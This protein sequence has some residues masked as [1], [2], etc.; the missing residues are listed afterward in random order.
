MPC[1]EFEADPNHSCIFQPYHM[2]FER[3]LTDAEWKRFGERVDEA[4]N[5]ETWAPCKV[6]MIAKE[7]LG[8]SVVR[9][10]P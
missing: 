9:F 3:R 6:A 2:V 1:P 7:E 4:W 10:E 8:V 5:G